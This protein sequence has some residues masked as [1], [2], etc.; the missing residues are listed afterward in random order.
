M[1]SL[2]KG[3]RP[4]KDKNVRNTKITFENVSSNKCNKE[5]THNSSKIFEQNNL[6]VKIKTY[7]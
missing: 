6:T 2:A 7:S 4:V 5:N 1:V 3:I